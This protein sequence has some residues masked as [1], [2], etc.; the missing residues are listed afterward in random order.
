MAIK[1]DYFMKLCLAQGFS[2][3][4]AWLDVSVVL[5]LMVYAW[6]V[7]PYMQ[8]SYFIVLAVASCLGSLS[9]SVIADYVSPARTLIICNIFRMIIMLLYVT[10]NSSFFLLM[11]VF[12]KT[13]I[14]AFYDPGTQVIIRNSFSD[15]E[16][17]AVNSISNTIT[18]LIRI[19]APMLGGGLLLLIS[20]NHVFIICALFLRYFYIFFIL[21]FFYYKTPVSD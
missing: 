9:S 19:I 1:N 12:I 11:C 16:L 15:T 17:P 8:A 7:S 3:L 6:N 4:A 10:T 13:F 20:P 14:S 18:Q 5:I 21:D 2:D